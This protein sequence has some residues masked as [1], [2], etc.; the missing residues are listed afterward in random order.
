MSQPETSVEG[1]ERLINIFGYWPSFHDAEVIQFDLWRG[2]VDP[3]ARRYIFPTVTTKIHLWEITTDLDTRGYYVLRH[4]TLATLRFYDMD[5]LRMEGF[6]HQ[7]AIFGLSISP[8]EP[9]EAFPQRFHIHFEPAFGITATFVCSR[10]EVLHAEPY[11]QA[12]EKA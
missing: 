8:A 1:A 12:I 10:V 11:L 6:N 9:T 4:H 3:D 5:Q 2:D 7:N